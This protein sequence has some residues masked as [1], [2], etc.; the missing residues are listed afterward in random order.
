MLPVS[1][2][3]PIY[4]HEHFIEQC[5][6]SIAVSA[7]QP[8]Q[9]VLVDNASTDGS[10]AAAER[11]GL[12]N[13]KIVRNTDN[14]GATR[15]RYVGSDTVETPYITFLDSDDLLGPEAIARAYR[16]LRAS[17]LDVSLFK[18]LRVSQDG[19]HISPFIDVPEE[20]MTG[21]RA[22]EL[23]L[24]PWSIHAYGIYRTSSYRRAM[25]RFECHGFSDDEVLARHLLLDAERVGGSD[26]V[27][28][29]RDV[30]KPYTFD[31]VVKQTR[32]NLRVL[33]MTAEH[34]SKLSTEASLRAMRNVV[35][36]NLAGLLVRVTRHGGDRNEVRNLY[37]EY[38]AI[39]VP[40]RAADARYAAMQ[41]VCAT[42][43]EF[44]FPPKAAHRRSIH[45]ASTNQE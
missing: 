20:I 44:G 41:L 14:V 25:S 2:V 16:E 32:T 38:A 23:T 35:I 26:G 10:I 34:R 7:G 33:Q 43:L 3:I 5:L 31:K 22:F 24:G 30:R 40:W 39:A 28:Y 4:N 21:K 42:A 6:R 19:S 11:L 9:I 27:Y 37:R 12:A 36:R 1:I 29:Y 45:S 8:A 15:A 13:L 18:C 17:E